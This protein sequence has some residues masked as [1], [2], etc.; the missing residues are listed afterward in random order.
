MNPGFQAFLSDKSY[1]CSGV[2]K[3]RVVV[4][5]STLKHLPTWVQ[6]EARNFFESKHLT[7]ATQKR[8]LDRLHAQVNED[9]YI[10]LME[11]MMRTDETAGDEFLGEPL[12]VGLKRPH[13]KNVSYYKGNRFKGEFTSKTEGRGSTATIHARFDTHQAQVLVVSEQGNNPP[14]LNAFYIDRDDFSNSYHESR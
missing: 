6:H 11:E 3:K 4:V 1:T 7:G 2:H 14:V 5:V 13:S 12:K 8:D 10:G 9:L